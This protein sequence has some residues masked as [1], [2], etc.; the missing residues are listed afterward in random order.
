MRIDRLSLARY[1]HFT[2]QEIDLNGNGGG[3]RLHVLLG[4]NEAG[5]TTALNAIADLL[6]GI[7]EKTSYAFRHGY[8]DLRIG[9]TLSAGSGERIT[10]RRRKGRQNTLLDAEDRPVAESVLAKVLGGVDRKTFTGLFGLTH[11]SLRAGGDDM[12]AAKG[13]LGRMLFEAGSSLAGVL[14]VLD[15]LD[16]EAAALFTPRRSAGKPFYVADEARLAAERKVTELALRF[17]DWRRNESELAETEAA[18]GDVRARLKRLEERRALLERIRRIAPRLESLRQVEAELLGLAAAALLPEDAGDRLEAAQRT[19]AV[20]GARLDR[21]EA[22]AAEAR[23][24]LAGLDIPEALL[25]ACDDI[26]RLYERRGA[27][28]VGRETLRDLLV[29]RGSLQAD[30]ESAYDR[31][32]ALPGAGGRAVPP[33]CDVALAELRR[34]IGEDGDLCNRLQDIQDRRAAAA[35]EV[36]AAEAELKAAAVPPDL[37][38]LELA[39][40]QAQCAGGLEGDLAEAEQAKIG[41]DRRLAKAVAALR[42]WSGGAAALA[43]LP[44]PERETVLRF[45]RRFLDAETL[46][47]RARDGLA[48]AREEEGRCCHELAALGDAADLP[49]AEAVVGARAVRDQGWEL[50]RRLFIDGERLADAEVEAFAPRP[51]V[52]ERYERAVGEA[53]A[54]AD[55]RQ[56]EAE[57]IARHDQLVAGRAAAAAR[58]TDCAARVAERERELAALEQDWCA[59]WQAIGI[60]AETPREMDRW[61]NRRED[62]L[63]A[64]DAAEAAADHLAEVR[65]R[66]LRERAELVAALVFAGGEPSGTAPF[67]ALIEEGRLR[68]DAGRAA[69]RARAAL[70]QKCKSQ[71]AT[72][73]AED[74]RL[75]ALAERR[76]G[77]SASWRTALEAVGLPAATSP[78]A[79]ATALA[80]WE[81]VRERRAELGEVERRITRIEDDAEAFGTEAGQL[82]AEVLPAL[83]DQEP[84]AAVHAA[85]ERLQ[86]ACREAQKQQELQA[87]LAGAAEAVRAAAAN[88]EDARAI[89]HRLMSMAGCTGE[90]ALPAAIERSRRK[91]ILL[92]RA[93][94][95]R[96][97][98]L[99]D[100]DGHGLAEVSAEAESMD[101]DQCRADLAALAREID[102]LFAETQ[103]LGARRQALAQSREQMAS[104]GGAIEAEQVRR[105]AL[106]DLEDV[107]ERWLVLK[108][109]AFLLR[110]GVEQFR[111][112]QQG[113]LLARAEALF[114]DLTLGGFARFRIDYDGCDQ[115]CLL[116][117]RGD[118]STCPTTGMS[119][120]TRDQLFLALRLAA[121]ERYV[122]QAE[123]LPFVADDLF[124][125]FDDARASAGLESLIALGA[126][127]QVLLFTHHRHLAELARQLGG[128]NRVRVQA[129]AAAA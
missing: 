63:A 30:L 20:A 25:A 93:D 41:A 106:A 82:L 92:A 111:R 66:L 51:R 8:K 68:L 33:P 114:R 46:L 126:K 124:V 90:T 80:L 122:A 12:L 49:T 119:D 21:E 23:R 74:A 1:G 118:G 56:R 35:A 67:A 129:L 120:G 87:R 65:D 116:G 72:L 50:I 42:L 31:L 62:A 113:P 104:G 3:T 2:D 102:E 110:R 105:N 117:V 37:T 43:A 109:A 84:L 22:V 77:W 83:V 61:L 18:L 79:A 6:F 45:E 13:D 99:S 75:D 89:I 9:A 103:R 14:R 19:A 40:A 26:Q 127:T 53:D 108:T 32:G 60:R 39:V 73:Q 100:A 17:D 15:A 16:A 71:V 38:R 88:A 112:E 48:M 70:R 54:L 69:E 107:G 125:H 86:V 101:P 81:G 10:I 121:I 64:H 44:V 95:L 58:R 36:V 85:F 7:E 27:V 11:A 96:D 34:L 57:R 4:A 78:A 97:E 76:A 28:L 29:R 5:K 52:A 94:G 128:G 123:P 115:P 98:I 91:A 47:L 24:E 55:R 59:L